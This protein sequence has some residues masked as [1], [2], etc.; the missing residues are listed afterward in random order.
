MKDK[1]IL[2]KACILLLCLVFAAALPLVVGQITPLERYTITFRILEEENGLPIA[3]ATVSI[4]GPVTESRVSGSDGVAIFTD[5]PVGTYSV[6][7][8]APDYAVKSSQSIIL[9]T[10]TTIIL[11]FST[12]KAFFEYTPSIITP[13]TIVHFNAS[14]SNSSGVITAYEWDFGDN[15]TGTNITTTHMFAKPGQ[16]SA[17]LTVK[18]TVGIATY[19][20]IITVNPSDYNYY[21]PLLV[22]VPIPLIILLLYR[23]RKYYI[24]IQA[25]IPPHRK[26][27]RCP[28][29][30]TECENCKLTPC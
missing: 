10:D 19:T 11:L 26:H 9:N 13:K 4:R 3:N 7:A 30:D 16:Y 25:R 6:T 21:T 14:Q 23:R 5:I 27:S 12:T 17:S 1:P 18:S 8:T 22:F 2:N 15:H 29:D 20:Q 28:G 24:V